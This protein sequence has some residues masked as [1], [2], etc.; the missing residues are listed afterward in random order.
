[1]AKKREDDSRAFAMAATDCAG[2][3]LHER[4]GSGSAG[5]E[6]RGGLLRDCD[7]HERPAAADGDR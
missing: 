3:A 7:G 2:A 5:F 6:P 4:D 1:M